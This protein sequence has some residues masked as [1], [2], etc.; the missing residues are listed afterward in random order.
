MTDLPRIVAIIGATA[1]GK[2]DLAIQVAE[3][4]RGEVVSVD[5]RL[6]YRGMDIGTAKPT[7]AERARVPHH[8]I[9]VVEPDET[10]SVARFQSAVSALIPEIVARDRLPILVGGTGQYMRAILQGWRPPPRPAD[11]RIR[12]RLEAEVEAGRGGELVERLKRVDPSSAE[13]IDLRNPRRVIRALEI[14]EATG[15]PAS[16][17]R[18][19]SPTPFRATCVGLTLPRPELY[20]RIDA[21]IDRMIEAGLVDEVRGLLAQGFSRASPSMSAIGYRE[22]AAHLE[23]AMTL[24]EAVRRMRQATRLFVRRQ[25]NWFRATDPSICWF[26]PAEGYEAGVVEWLHGELSSFRGASSS[27]E[28]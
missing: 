20:E 5:S 2:S 18:G 27:P 16:Q 1:T 9:D 13:T 6:I 21:R 3:W 22:I 26:T 10:W 11:R 19:R 17:Q 25:A 15:V 12:A 7:R 14:Y 4:F 28:A 23:G 24:E 8:L